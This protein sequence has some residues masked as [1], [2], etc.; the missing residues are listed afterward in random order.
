MC[1]RDSVDPETG[2]ITLVGSNPEDVRLVQKAIAEL[3]ANAARSQP[4][5][6]SI[7]LQ[8]VQSTA[9]AES[10]QELYDANYASGTGRATITAIESPNALLVVGQLE[11]VEVVRTLVQTID[12]DLGAKADNDFRTFK[13]VHI[14]AAD[15]KV[16]LDAYLSLIHI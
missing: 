7:S 1:I 8:N 4:T 15:A 6:Q 16:R 3:S 13:L 14:A 2:I 10:L 11:A 9:I 12:V 5:S